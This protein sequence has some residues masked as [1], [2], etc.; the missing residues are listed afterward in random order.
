MKI[1]QNKSLK[2]LNTFGVEADAKYYIN[3]TSQ[4]QLK[5]LVNE[6]VFL[7]NK[8]FILGGGSNVLFAAD[9]DGLIIHIDIKGMRMQKITE[10]YVIMETGAGENWHN[11]VETTVKN[12]YY[13]L[14]NLVL[15]P[16]NVG[17]APVQN[18]GAYG[19]EQDQFFHSLSGV[20]LRDNTIKELKPEDCRFGYRDSIFK[21]ELKDKFIITNVRYKLSKHENLNLSYAEL[22]R[23]IKKFVVVEP[24]AEYVMFTVS[25]LRRQKL[26]DPEE[27]G[28]AGS[29]F[30]N[31]IIEQDQFSKLQQSCPDIPN[32]KLDT[33]IKISA[34]W[35]IEQCG[36]KGKSKSDAGVSE[37]HALILVNH[38]N[39]TGGEI[40][41]LADEIR[42]S[43]DEKFGIR[44]ENEVNIIE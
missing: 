18:I 6:P 10:D 35:L 33:G 13:G 1:I 44:L 37:K 20:D 32:W 14:E 36:W 16:G 26:P 38:G 17:S 8:Y 30:K 43:V 19:A 5:K 23:E 24:S 25:R 42:N 2:S 3:I 9:F 27:K 15:I 29:F 7:E 40:I 31:P 11:F 34:A 39:A 4:D 12:R 21:N 22:E 41:K 28:N